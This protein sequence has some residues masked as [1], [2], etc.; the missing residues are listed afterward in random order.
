MHSQLLNDTFDPRDSISLDIRQDNPSGKV[1]PPILPARKQDQEEIKFD[2]D[3]SIICGTSNLMS[4]R[5]KSDRLPESN[6]AMSGAI[7]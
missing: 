3:N 6:S 4:Y 7:H 2:A 5:E 1:V